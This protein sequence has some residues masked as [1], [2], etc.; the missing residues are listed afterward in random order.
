MLGFNLLEHKRLYLALLPVIFCVP[1]ISASAEIWKE[2]IR[3]SSP[4][5]YGMVVPVL[6]NGSGPYKFLFDTGS[7]STV[8]DP[9][10]VKRLRLSNMTRTTAVEITGTVPIAVTVISRLE[11]GPVRTGPL[12]V[13]V[14]SLSALKGLDPTI[15][16]IL[17][18]DVLSQMDY[19]I[20]NDERLIEPDRSGEIQRRIP[21]ERIRITAMIK[22]E[23]GG[24]AGIIVPA[25]VSE[26]EAPRVRLLLDSGSA[27]LL[28]SSRHDNFSPQTTITD[29]DGK[30]AYSAAVQVRIR[31]GDLS[32]ATEARLTASALGPL[33]IDGLLPTGCFSK[34]YVSNSNG[35]VLLLPKRA[36][37][38]HS[39]PAETH[40]NH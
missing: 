17:G 6:V 2:P 29:A 21:G 37:N 23:D 10:I 7:T 32:F 20:D 16:G 5:G 31:I 27:F 24:M 12:T 3:F 40:A 25:E 34:V 1:A 4:N 11:F 26:T 15:H 9:H 19:L 36:R 14:D 35:F 28:L 33:P 39:D 22:P 38:D 13:I 30:R 8:V 18:E